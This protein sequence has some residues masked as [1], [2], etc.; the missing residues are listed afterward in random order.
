MTGHAS[1]EADDQ[2]RAA[3]AQKH[4]QRANDLMQNA[5]NGICAGSRDIDA[6]EVVCTKQIGEGQFGQVFKGK[7]H[8][9][10]CAVKR[11]KSGVSK[12]HLEY[13]SIVMEMSVLMTIGCHP[14]IVEF[15]GA[16]VDDSNNPMIVE[17]YAGDC[18]LDD[19]LEAKY[20][21]FDLG[22]RRVQKWTL[23]IL[24]ALEHLHGLNPVVVHRDVKPA[25]LLLTNNRQT[26]K[27]TDFGLSKVTPKEIE[28]ESDGGGE[29]APLRSLCRC[30]STNIGTP[31]FGAPEVFHP[32][33]GGG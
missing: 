15:I 25:N 7:Y 24:G 17:E 6:C 5:Q 16:C 31:R 13:Q 21:G 23:D 10:K 33:A 14:N 8:G 3:K 4:V 1:S 22:Y 26:L 18:N 9:K 30:H 20:P 29:E 28:S 12:E 2:L 11:L 32:A 19:Y 27:L